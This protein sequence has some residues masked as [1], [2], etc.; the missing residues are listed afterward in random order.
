MADIEG[1]TAPELRAAAAQY[2]YH[3]E[4]LRIIVGINYIYGIA[5]NDIAA[6]Y[7]ISERTVYNWVDRLAGG[8]TVDAVTDEERPGRPQITAVFR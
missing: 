1:V 6:M 4:I 7:G 8:V 5:P 3:T 2:E